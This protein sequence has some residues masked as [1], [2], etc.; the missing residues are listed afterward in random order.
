MQQTS[1]VFD[2]YSQM[3]Q[4]STEFD[5][6]NSDQTPVIAHS[7]GQALPAQTALGVSG[8]GWG[9][10]GGGGGV[11]VSRNARHHLAPP[12]ECWHPNV[13]EFKSCRQKKISDMQID[14]R[15]DLL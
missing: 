8:S 12:Q 9:G 13:N 14:R 11:A 15:K 10:V 5:C 2:C 4:A 7:A 1:T 6:Y 3:Q